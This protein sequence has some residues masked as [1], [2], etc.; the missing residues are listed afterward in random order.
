MFRDERTL[1]LKWRMCCTTLSYSK[2]AICLVS[3]DKGEIEQDIKRTVNFI[4]E[5]HFWLNDVVLGV[6]QVLLQAFH[7][8]TEVN[9]KSQD[10]TS[11]ITSFESATAVQPNQ[12]RRPMRAISWV[13]R[14]LV[15]WQRRNLMLGSKTRT[16]PPGK[17]PGQR[18]GA[19]QMFPTK[20]HLMLSSA[21][22]QKFDHIVSWQP[23]GR[24]FKVHQPLRFVDEVMPKW[25]QHTKFASFR[26]QLNL[27]GFSRLT[28]G[29][30][31]SG[32]DPILWNP[33]QNHVT[34]QLICSMFVLFLKVLSRELLA[35]T[36]WSLRK[37]GSNS[38]QG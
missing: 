7:S 13:L 16:S 25:F 17:P 28:T 5:Q 37:H 22:S 31:Y 36:T 9:L 11:K 14:V 21:E 6:K 26:R 18:A 30:D 35:R 4:Y 2:E 34:R 10:N 24:C 27:Y 12:T 1:R 23:H 33:S 38:R 15:C 3:G 29:A 20:L 19:G 8:S 32:Y